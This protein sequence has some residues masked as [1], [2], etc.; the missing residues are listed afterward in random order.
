MVPSS[1]TFDLASDASSVLRAAAA[2]AAEARRLAQMARQT[3]EL[4]LRQAAQAR[5]RYEEEAAEV[6]AE[7]A[8]LRRRALVDQARARAADVARQEVEA[9]AALRREADERRR[10]G[11]EEKEAARRRQAA[12]AEVEAVRGSAASALR[13]ATPFWG[14]ADT[15]RLRH[16]IDEARRAGV[17]G[18]A[19]AA[20]EEKLRGALARSLTLTLTLTLALTLTPTRRAG[21]ERGRKRGRCGRPEPEPP[22]R[23]IGRGRPKLGEA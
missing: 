16:A 18:G 20:A 4:V 11:Q 12:E 15:A 1:P 5:C 6:E 21:S 14:R 17:A 8:E 10:R 13:A 3:S 9:R 7:A 23:L 19:V 2:D 22:K